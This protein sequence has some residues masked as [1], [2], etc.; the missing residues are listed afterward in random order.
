MSGFSPASSRRNIFMIAMS[1]NT[2]EVLDCSADSA[3]L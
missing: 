3:R 1:P 2:S